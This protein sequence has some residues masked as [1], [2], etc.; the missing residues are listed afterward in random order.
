M[1]RNKEAY[2]YGEHTVTLSGFAIEKTEVTNAEYYE[3]IKAT[4]HTAPKNWSAG[5]PVK[6]TEKWPVAY[7]S[8][9]DANAYAKWRSVV[10]GVTYRLPT[11][12]EWEYV[13]RNGSKGNIFPWGDQWIEGNAVVG[14]KDSEPTDVGSKPTGANTWGVV[15]LIG[16]VW[17]W[18]SSEYKP[19]PGTENTVDKTKDISG[20][21]MIRGG[22]ADDQSAQLKVS[23][24]R[25]NPVPPDTTN[26]GLG[27]RLV[28]AGG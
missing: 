27:F 2:E 15:D 12:E 9:D 19:Y 7:V 20:Y 22:A 11:E 10:E 28:R 24:T 26:K 5:Q 25:R 21:I 4:N 1:G 6:Y 13:A 3:F 8:L 18:T 17:E 14:K 16:N 23:S